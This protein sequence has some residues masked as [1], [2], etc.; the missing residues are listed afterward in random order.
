[1]LDRSPGST[2][3]PATDV[4]TPAPRVDLFLAPELGNTSYLVS[5]PDA[6]VAAVIDPM[7]DVGQYLDAADRLGVRITH[8]LETHSHNDFISGARELAREAGTRIGAAEAAHLSF[9]HLPL[10]A[11]SSIPLG[12]WHL[13]TRPSPG[14]TPSHVSYLLGGSERPL[15]LFSGGALMAG[16]IA[17]TDLFGPDRAAALALEAYRTLH[18][19]LRD[20]PDDVALYPTHGGG[21]FCATGAPAGTTSTLGRER[22]TN[23]YL[24]TT[25]LMAFMARALHQTRHP[26]YYAEMTELNRTGVAL[27]GR[28]LPRLHDLTADEVAQ[29]GAAGAVVVDVRP[30]RL[31]DREHIPGSLCIGIGGAFSAWAGWLIPRNRPIVLTGGSDREHREAQRQLFRI[32]YDEVLGALDGGV[33]AWR[34]GGREVGRFE[35]AEV[36]ELATWILSGERVTVLDVRNEDEWVHGHVPG[37]RHVHVA[38]VSHHAHELPLDA[39]VAV[40]CAAGYRSAIAASLLG[41]AGVPHVV[42]VDGPLTDWERLNLAE[43]HP[44]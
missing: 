20:L 18:V 31:F 10:R 8:A 24:Q 15:G 23:P 16:A 29:T 12:R 11:G 2:T 34:A 37:A 30:G 40:Y 17:R 41:R 42:H 32:G 6:G 44:G 21:S 9:D 22:L 3:R 36:A 19:R 14:H 38:D 25:D 1:M 28:E 27:V 39:P 35:S 33:D 5:D 13:D 7:R 43:T 26:D 4:L